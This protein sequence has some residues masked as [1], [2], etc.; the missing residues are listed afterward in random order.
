MTDVNLKSFNI[1]PDNKWVFE[2][3]ENSEVVKNIMEDIKVEIPEMIKVS[4]VREVRSS[5]SAYICIPTPFKTY[6]THTAK[7]IKIL[8]R[9]LEGGSKD[10]IAFDRI[11]S[12]LRSK[13]SKAVKK[14]NISENY[15]E[16]LGCSGEDFLKHIEKQFQDGMTWDNYGQKGWHID[17]IKPLCSFNLLEPDEVRKATH[18]TNLR[19]LWAKANIA[20]G[21]EDKKLSIRRKVNGNKEKS[22]S[23]K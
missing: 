2:I 10:F 13:V 18:F 7:L 15:E 11:A 22:K 20:K 17:H 3:V 9:H 1:N 5:I 19:P 8:K 23:K 21:Q 6:T 14:L 4:S 12:R 16:L